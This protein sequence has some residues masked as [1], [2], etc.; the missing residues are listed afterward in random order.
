MSPHDKQQSSVEGITDGVKHIQTP[1]PSKP[2]SKKDGVKH[3]QSPSPSKPPPPKKTKG[4]AKEDSKTTAVVAEGDSK[5]PPDDYDD[6]GPLNEMEEEEDKFDDDE[7]LNATIEEGVDKVQGK[8]PILTDLKNLADDLQKYNLFLFP[9]SDLQDDIDIECC[10]NLSE[11][12]RSELLYTIVKVD[13]D[14]DGKLLV[15]KLL[16]ATTNGELRAGYLDKQY[17]TSDD[18]N[19]IHYLIVLNLNHMNKNANDHVVKTIESICERYCTFDKEQL[20]KMTV[21]EAEDMQAEKG[22]PFTFLLFLHYI[23]HHKAFKVYGVF[24]RVA[25]HFLESGLQELMTDSSNDFGLELHEHA[26][27]SVQHEFLRGECYLKK[28]VQRI[29]TIAKALNEL[30]NVL[31]ERYDE[32]FVKYLRTKII[33][34]K[35]LSSW[36]PDIACYS[37]TNAILDVM[38]GIDNWWNAYLNEHPVKRGEGDVYDDSQFSDAQ[39]EVARK[40]FSDFIAARS[41]PGNISAVDM[42]ARLFLHIGGNAESFLKRQGWERITDLFDIADVIVYG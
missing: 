6:A 12:K 32:E 22:I 35:I 24:K 9:R 40:T 37:F 36:A 21:K 41:N 27:K 19:D 5:M 8:H 2:A 23:H 38:V 39:H 29:K 7:N 28:A 18:D 26:M 34:M 15:L 10:H 13:D 42:N 16:G 4:D 25:L 1:S 3:I 31:A 20:Q 30:L 11:S 17:N 33:I 14:D